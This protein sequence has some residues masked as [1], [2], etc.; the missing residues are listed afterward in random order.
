MRSENPRKWRF[1]WE[2]QSHIPI[3]KLYLFSAQFNPINHCDNLIIDLILEKSILKLRW[4]DRNLLNLVNLTVP[5]PRV[6]I[7]LESPLHFRTLDDHIEVKIPLLLPV[8]HP[9]VASFISDLHSGYDELLTPLT[10]DSGKQSAFI[11]HFI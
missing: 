6:L 11:L 10:M 4:S 8:D 7:D 2:S 1:T 5:L 9:I 3:L